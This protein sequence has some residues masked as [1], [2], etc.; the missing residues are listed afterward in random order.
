MK[1]LVR[2]F[3]TKKDINEKLSRLALEG[4]RESGRGCVLIS[5]SSPMA[6]KFFLSSG[7]NS[8]VN[9]PSYAT[10]NEVLNDGIVTK[11]QVLL[12]QTLLDYNP[13]IEFV[14]NLIVF[15]G[16]QNQLQSATR[17]RFNSSS[18]LRCSKIPLNGIFLS[19]ELEPYPETSYEIRVFY[20]PKSKSHHFINETEARRYYC[21]EVSYGLRK[22]GVVLK[23]DYPDAYDKLCLYVEHNV[24]FLPITLYGQSK[25]T[26]YKCIVFPEE[27]SGSSKTLELQGRGMLV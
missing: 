17:S 27:F 20:L 5:F 25:G 1:A 2:R 15:V 3:E 16:K 8:F 22:Y 4:F 26:N 9:D 13:E 24:E 21:R 14:V 6:A 11:H 18:L 12:Q 7:T 23:R 10:L 19:H